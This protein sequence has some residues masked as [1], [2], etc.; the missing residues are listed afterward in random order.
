[1]GEGDGITRRQNAPSPWLQGLG[2]MSLSSDFDKLVSKLPLGVG[3]VQIVALD[4][5]DCV[6]QIKGFTTLGTL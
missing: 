6:R 3:V 4:F 2:S 1:M 5:C